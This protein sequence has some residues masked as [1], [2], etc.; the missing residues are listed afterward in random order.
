MVYLKSKYIYCERVSRGEK[1]FKFFEYFEYF[2][3]ELSDE[4][5]DVVFF[6]L[7]C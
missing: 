7:K 1:I 5:F 2:F 6:L 4:I 3:C